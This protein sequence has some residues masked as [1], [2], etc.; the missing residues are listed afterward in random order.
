MKKNLLRLFAI[1]LFGGLIIFSLIYDSSHPLERAKITGLR[2]GY[3]S[4]KGE[5]IYSTSIPITARTLKI[6]GVMDKSKPAP[7]LFTISD[8]EDIN[9]YL[10][11][12][13]YYFELQPGN[14]CVNLNLANK[15]SPDKYTLW[16]MDG[17]VSVAQL[18]IEFK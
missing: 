3:L 10:Y 11:Q 8:P 17:R 16:I 5:W 12:D 18:A 7:L 14:F 13:E 2:L 6:C 9:K 15:V 4:D 1:I